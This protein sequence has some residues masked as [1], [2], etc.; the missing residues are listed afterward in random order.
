M[1]VTVTIA[2]PALTAE[3]NPHGAE[4]WSLRDAAG[5]ELTPRTPTRHSGPVMRRCSSPW[6]ASP[7]A[8]RFA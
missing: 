7:R 1:P 6:S 5:R 3:L 4:L 2:S 8:R